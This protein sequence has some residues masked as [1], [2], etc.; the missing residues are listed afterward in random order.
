RIVRLSFVVHFACSYGNVEKIFGWRKRTGIRIVVCTVGIVRLV[1]VELDSRR[2]RHLLDVQITPCPIRFR[3]ARPVTKRE[4][5]AALLRAIHDLENQ[6]AIL[7]VVEVKSGP[8][9]LQV[10]R[11]LSVGRGKRPHAP[12]FDGMDGGLDT[13][14]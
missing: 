9:V 2:T 10:S 6:Q 12:S 3:S 11:L 7:S 8:R 4:E 14:A 1:E 5:K 13:I